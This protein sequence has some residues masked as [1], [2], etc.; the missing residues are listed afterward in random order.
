MAYTYQGHPTPCH[1][2]ACSPLTDVNATISRNPEN[3]KTTENKSVYVKLLNHV[4]PLVWTKNPSTSTNAKE[5]RKSPPFH[6]ANWRGQQEHMHRYPVFELC[7]YIWILHDF[8]INSTE[9]QLKKQSV[10]MHKF[11]NQS[12]RAGDESAFVAFNFSGTPGRFFQ[13]AARSCFFELEAKTIKSSEVTSFM[14]KQHILVIN[15]RSAGIKMA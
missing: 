4:K 5:K 7:T 2:H 10:V 15:I 6:R 12:I 14:N 9:K 8:V 1:S 11:Q 13:L 3:Q